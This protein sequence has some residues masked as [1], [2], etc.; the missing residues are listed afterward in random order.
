MIYRPSHYAAA[1]RNALSSGVSFEIAR[2]NLLSSLE[3]RGD[4]HRFRQ[5]V[6]EIE[7][8]E[9]RAHGGQCVTLEFAHEPTQDARTALTHAFGPHDRVSST[10]RSDLIAG[11]RITIDDERELDISLAGKLRALFH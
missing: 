9:T 2:K 8:L 4:G 3:K 5:V 11:V 6:Q 10:V 7:R 1:F